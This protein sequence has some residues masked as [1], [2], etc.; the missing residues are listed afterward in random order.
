MIRNIEFNTQQAYEPTFIIGARFGTADDPTPVATLV[1]HAV[2]TLEQGRL[3]FEVL[4][5]LTLYPHHVVGMDHVM[6]VQSL[7]LEFV[8]F[9]T[10]HLLPTFRE[11]EMPDLHVE[12]PYAI[13]GRKGIEM[14][15]F[16]NVAKVLVKPKTRKTIGETGANKLHQQVQV[17]ITPPGQWVFGSRYQDTKLGRHPTRFDLDR[18]STQHP[19]YL[20]HSSG[21][22][23]AVNSLALELARIT[24][25]S[26]DPRGGGFDRLEDGTPNGVLRESAKSI[27][28]NAGPEPPQATTEEKLT[29][30]KKRFGKYLSKGITSIQVAGTSPSSVDFYRLLQSSG[31]RIR[32][33]V[34][35]RPANIETLRQWQDQQGLGNENLKLGAIKHFH[36]NSLSGRTCWLYEPY[37]DRPDYFG[38][39][40][41]ASQQELNETVWRIHQAGL[42]ACIHSNGDREIDMVLNAYEQALQRLPRDDHRHRIEHCSVVNADILKR[43]KE[44]GVVLAL[45]SYVYEHGDKMEAYGAARWNWMH[46]NRTAIDMGIPVAGNSDSPVSAADPLLRIQSMVTR[47]SAEGK[48]Y[49]PRQ[50][51]TVEQALRAWTLGSAF[52]SFD[53]QIKGSITVGKLADFV[54]LNRDPLSVPPDELKDIQVDVT[55]IGGH[56]VYERGATGSNGE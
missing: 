18:A 28:R 56:V 1:A 11:L 19:I 34:M 39:P 38:I 27:V 40:P 53:E 36:G 48:V 51:V 23:A 26:P 29:G 43:V 4:P 24:K 44:L 16:A 33:Y 6:P 55:V 50:R 2:N 13:V 35:L 52:A 32:M 30:Y 49:G 31:Q 9:I 17:D 10:H 20:T 25:D 45:H 14:I 22:V 41:K 12:I 42:Q 47:K 54:V 15:S 3:A 37:A 21:H 7:I 46:V 5:D 8:G